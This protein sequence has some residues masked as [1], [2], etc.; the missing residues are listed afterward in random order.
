MQPLFH[1]LSCL[2][3]DLN[4]FRLF[5][6]PER[7]QLLRISALNLSARCRS[8]NEQISKPVAFRRWP[9]GSVP[10]S[11][12]LPECL[13]MFS[14]FKFIL[15]ISSTG[16]IGHRNSL[17]KPNTKFDSCDSRNALLIAAYSV[18]QRLRRTLSRTLPRTLPRGAHC[19]QRRSYRAQ[20]HS[21]RMVAERLRTEGNAISC[22][23][24]P[25]GGR[26]C[27]RDL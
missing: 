1:L 12:R 15:W 4:F 24:Q 23:G 3:R 27:L 22:S 2:S 21:T 13:S 8:A 20:Q 18:G 16:S 5:D 26:L 7:L 14:N 6:F 25:A 19:N 10:N 11:L 9:L 17:G